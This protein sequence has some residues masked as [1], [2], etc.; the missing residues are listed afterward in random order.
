MFPFDGYVYVYPFCGQVPNMASPEYTHIKHPAN[1]F[2]DS[3]IF[4]QELY[5]LCFHHKK[6]FAYHNRDYTFQILDGDVFFF[7]PQ[8]L[9]TQTPPNI[10]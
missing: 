9:D 8:T 6:Q 5:L 7:N 1:I 2:L 10:W 4:I 3:F